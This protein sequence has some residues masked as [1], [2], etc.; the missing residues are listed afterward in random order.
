MVFIY[1]EKQAS[2]LA[3]NGHTGS[4]LSGASF[5]SPPGSAQS[6]GLAAG[7]GFSNDWKNFSPVFQRMETFSGANVLVFGLAPGFANGMRLEGDFPERKWKRAR[8]RDGVVNGG[9]GFAGW[10]GGMESWMSHHPRLA[11]R[12]DFTICHCVILRFTD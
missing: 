1:H 10:R 4:V 9:M 12:H 5:F 7:G 8:G 3:I 11:T 2:Y 6:A